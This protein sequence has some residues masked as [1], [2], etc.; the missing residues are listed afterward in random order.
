MSAGLTLALGAGATAAPRPPTVPGTPLRIV[1][2]AGWRVIDH[3][4]ALVLIK[5]IG[6]LDPQLASFVSV[7]AKRG[8]AIRLVALD[9]RSTGGFATNANVVVQ[10]S[11]AASIARVVALE[12]PAVRQVLHPIGLKESAARAAGHQAISVTFEALFNEP[13]PQERAS[14]AAACARIVSSLSF[15]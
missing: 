4:T 13:L 15:G 9:T 3:A 5:R 14:Y 2:P 12:L 8:S 11:P 6:A 7:L 10:P 1:L